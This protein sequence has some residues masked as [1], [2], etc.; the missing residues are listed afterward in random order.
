MDA[1]AGALLE[2]GLRFVAAQVLRARAML[3]PD[4]TGADGAAAEARQILIDLGAVTMLRGLPEPTDLSVPASTA[5]ETTAR[6][7]ASDLIPA[8]GGAT[9]GPYPSGAHQAGGASVPSLP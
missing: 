2:E 7:L 6:A 9:I 4:D 5:V 3:A 8:S 1:A